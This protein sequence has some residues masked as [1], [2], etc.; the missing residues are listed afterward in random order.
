MHRGSLKTLEKSAKAGLRRGKQRER[1]RER[2]SE[3]A[4]ELHRSSVPTLRT[5]EAERLRRRLGARLRLWRSVPGR[6][7]MLAV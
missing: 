5:P 1:E 6:G 7:L 3:R 2:E 4:R